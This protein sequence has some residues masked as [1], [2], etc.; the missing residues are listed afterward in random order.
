MIQKLTIWIY[1][2]KESGGKTSSVSQAPSV[3]SSKVEDI[4]EQ[5][6]E[7]KDSICGNLV[8]DVYHT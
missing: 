4:E 3:S 5:L 8:I 6:H 2:I 7:R 1:M